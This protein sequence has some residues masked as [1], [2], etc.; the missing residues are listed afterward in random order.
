MLRITKSVLPL[1]LSLV[2]L[3]LMV[4]RISPV[5]ATGDI[6]KHSSN[7]YLQNAE[8][9]PIF[10]LGYYDWASVDPNSYAHYEVTYKKMIDD[11]YANNLNYLRI[12]LGINR[13][14]Q[15]DTPVPFKY[16]N[17]K[18][19]LDQWD[20]NFWNGLVYHCDYAKQK[21][22]YV[23]VAFFD[24]C[25]IKAPGSS[26]DNWKRWPGS[27]WNIDNQTKSFYGDLDSDNDNNCDESGGFYRTNDFKNSTGV[28]VYQKKLIDK[29]IAVCSSHDNVFFEVGNEC[30]SPSGWSDAVI[31]YV[32]TKTSR[33]I[34]QNYG[35]LATN[36]DGWA[37]H[38]SDTASETKTLVAANVG[39]GFV[40]W[41]D[42][43]G[44]DLAKSST[45]ADELRKAAWYSFSGGSAGWTGFTRYYWEHNNTGNSA[46]LGT[47]K[48][49]SNFITTTR[50]PFA[51]MVPNHSLV[52]NNGT[53][54]CL[55]KA[56][57]TYLA[58]IPDDSSIT[59]DLSGA[60]GTLKY[61]TYDP[62]A[63][64]YSAEQSVSGGAPRT[65]N[66]P[67][68]AS[69]WVIYV[70]NG[71]SGS[72][73]TPTTPPTEIISNLTVNDS[74]NEADW[75]VKTNIQ[76]S[77]QQYGDRTFTFTTMPSS[78]VGCDW[79]RTANDSKM[80]TGNT[81]VTFM[82]TKN[83]DVYVAHNDAITTKPSWLSG[84]SDTSENIVNS[85]SPAKIFSVYKKNF[86]SNSMVSLGSNGSTTEGM[87]TIIVK[88]VSGG[89]PTPT[90]TPAPTPTPTPPTTDL[91]T[92][93][94]IND[95]NNAADW[96]IL[97]NLQIN[98]LV[99]GDRTYTF[100]TI[101]TTVL[102]CDWISTA[103]DS[104][105]YT[106]N[107]LATFKVNADS[108]VY[109]AHND[110]ITTKPSWM[111]DYTDAGENITADDFSST[112]TRSLFKK[113]FNAGDTVSLGIN[114]DTSRSMYVVIV[115][116]R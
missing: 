20:S 34:T 50:I 80:Y 110:L 51:T 76:S 113:S 25:D 36:R 98:D 37:T 92:N 83:A 96:S 61:K 45:S 30:N 41:D 11:A 75:S 116:R 103:N 60:S 91:I 48:K 32:K 109:I 21:G 28:G 81:L 65:F 78:V 1:F 89:T 63:A 64:T 15:Y 74:S 66:K 68:G 84:W 70:Y 101:P 10:L 114:G 72:T 29:A 3:L 104:R 85:E 62:K 56:G 19:D 90:P 8:G 9:N 42:T 71:T 67:S 4:F 12:S 18:F 35:S 33:A 102:G 59:L 111:S 87:Y 79:I 22:V 38:G 5:C 40:Y 115:K 112:I 107:T 54:S 27:F 108:D 13:N 88:E 43:D 93:L 106:G 47:Y 7:R 17:G 44:P 86:A 39:K 49:L 14:P 100:D 69:D 95:S 73:P 6:L 23:H 82:V 52:S 99:F 46:V 57:Q 16:V 2:L 94:D 31:S 26:A 24:G 97:S 105:S 53:N 55:A 58:Y 77:N